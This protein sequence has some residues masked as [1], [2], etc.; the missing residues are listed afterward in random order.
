MKNEYRSTY[1]EVFAGETRWNV[2]E[3][4]EDKLYEWQ[5]DSTY[6][7]KPPYFEGITPQPDKP[8]TSRAPGYWHCWVTPLP[9]TISRLPAPSRPTARQVTT[10]GNTVLHQATS[11]HWDLAGAT[12]KS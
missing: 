7:R 4:P 10:S 6:I 12:M 9:Q 11:T 8:G 2:L 1:E 5:D 3:S